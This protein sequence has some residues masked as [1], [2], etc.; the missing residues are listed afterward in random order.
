MDGGNVHP[1]D[2]AKYF[3]VLDLTSKGKRRQINTQYLGY[4]IL[5]G[6]R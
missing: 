2:G 6:D 1:Q 4:Q 5:L 3:N